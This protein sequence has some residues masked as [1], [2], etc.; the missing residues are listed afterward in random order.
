LAQTQWELRDATL[1]ALRVERAVHRIHFGGLPVARELGESERY[2]GAV[3][4]LSVS[5][6]YEL[7]STGAFSES[8][9]Q[10]LCSVSSTVLMHARLYVECCWSLVRLVA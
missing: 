1:V 3:L 10:C 8:R 9:E 4:F 7:G 2:R 6:G 5:V